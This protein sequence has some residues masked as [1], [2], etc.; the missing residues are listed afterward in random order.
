MRKIFRILFFTG[1][2]V[3]IVIQ[4]FQPDRNA[5]DD[6]SNHILEIEK[7]PDN[8]K[9]VLENSCLDCHS[10]QT[11]YLWYHKMA[12]VSWMID[13]HIQEGKDELNFSEWGA[14]DIYDKIETL[15]EMYQEV[16]R[17]KMPLKSYTSIHKKAKLSEKQEAE[18]RAWTEKLGLELLAKIEK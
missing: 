3:F 14:F 9:M 2:L 4:F 17:K 11:N 7:V 10:N 8:I 6:I 18:L 15:E 12:P 5:S 13:K 16:E 1:L